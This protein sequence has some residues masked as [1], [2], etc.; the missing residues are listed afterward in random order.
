MNQEW[1]EAKCLWWSEKRYTY[2]KKYMVFDFRT[3]STQNKIN[4]NQLIRNWPDGVV[5]TQRY[6]SSLGYYHDLVR[7]YKKSQ[8]IEPVGRGAYKKFGGSVNFMGGIHAV[9]KQLGLSI[10]PGGRTALEWQGYAH[11]I[12]FRQRCF[13]FGKTGQS[14]PKWFYDAEWEETF[15]YH[16]TN[17]FSASDVGLTEYKQM[18]FSLTISAPER[19]AL[20]MCYLIPKFQGFDEAEKI[21]NGLRA[22][23]PKLVQDLLESCKSIKAKRLFLYLADHS[24]APWFKGLTLDKIDLGKGKRMIVKNGKYDAKYQ[25]SVP[26]IPEL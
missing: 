19:A 6:L 3:M 10:Y 7:R 2:H 22:L 11:Y 14:L 1:T 15:T 20:E 9:Q 24:R 13:L 23:R 21:M 12:R 26:E 17:L 5:Y 25:I 8:W 4:I 18:R 16:Q